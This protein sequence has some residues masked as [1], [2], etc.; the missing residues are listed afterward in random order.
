MVTKGEPDMTNKVEFFYDFGSPTAYLAFKRLPSIAARHGAM[1]LYRPFL[2]GGVFKTVGTHS[3]VENPAK[4]EWMWRDL[5][6]FA[7]RDGIPMVRNP[8]FP[9]NTLPIM[10][11]AMVAARDDVLV[12]YSEAM[13]DA[14]W[15]DGRNLGDPAV[16]G[17]VIGAAGLDPKRYFAGVD[18]ADIKNALKASTEEAIAR[19]AFGAPTFFVGGEMHFGQDRLDFVEAALSAS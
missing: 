2:L 1:I 15:R 16:I 18:E 6:R 17:A 13:F 14:I 8:H 12:P 5:Q 3:P 10:R 4:G 7:A 9:I 19:G 11:G